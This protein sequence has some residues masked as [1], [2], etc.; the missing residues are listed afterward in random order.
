MPARAFVTARRVCAATAATW[1]AVGAAAC[2]LS[3][4]PDDS[5]RVFYTPMDRDLPGEVN[6]PEHPTIFGGATVLIRGAMVSPCGAVDSRAER[7]GA[8]VTVRIASLD[9]TRRCPASRYLQ[10]FEAE[11]TGLR[12]GRYEIRVDITSV[13]PVK[14]TV[15]EIAGD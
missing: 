12:P 15:L 9:D 5:L 7:V 8:V 1:L 13:A 6:W 2:S 4:G 10:P 11:V 3:L 14:P